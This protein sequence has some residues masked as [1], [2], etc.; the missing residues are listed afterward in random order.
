M[1]NALFKSFFEWTYL[2]D[3][4]IVIKMSAYISNNLVS[5]ATTVYYFLLSQMLSNHLQFEHSEGQET[6]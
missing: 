5:G 2:F 1:S 3:M 6:E 4:Y